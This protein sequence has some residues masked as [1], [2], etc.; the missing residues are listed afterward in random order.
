MIQNILKRKGGDIFTVSAT[1]SLRVASEKMAAH[2]VAALFIVDERGLRGLISER[3][4]IQMIADQGEWA[5]SMPV[6]QVMLKSPPT[7]EPTD[8][9]RH[10]MHVMTR[11]RARHL[12]VIDGAK[13]IGVVSIGDVVKNRL[14]DL[15]T[16]ANVLRDVY[17]AAAH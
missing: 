7:V 10:A 3:E 5:L 14:E 4:I 6:G 13:M 2:G 15:E 17:I 9:L 1:E 12:A 16:E 11:S 8:S